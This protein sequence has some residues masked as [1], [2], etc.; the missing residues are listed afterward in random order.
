M[1]TPVNCTDSELSTFLRGLAEGYLP[2]YYSDTS[3]SAQSKS[4]PIASKSY[5]HG[6]KT[7]SFLGFPSLTMLKHSTESR[8]ED[9]LKSS[10]AAF[11]VRTFHAQEKGGGLKVKEA[12][13]GGKWQESLA[14]F[15][16]V[17]RSWK[18]RQLC[19]FAD[20]DESLETWPK[21]GIMQNGVASA[22]ETPLGPT[23]EIEFGFSLPTPTRCDCSKVSSNP[24]FWRRRLE[25]GRSGMDNLPEFATT[26]YPGGD[27]RIHP[28]L[29]EWLM[30]WPAGMTDLKPLETD[31]FQ[32]W[33]RSHGGYS[34]KE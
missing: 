11:P 29:H 33:L 1:S 27:G 19:L 3:P 12:E 15:D 30:G 10:R 8:G 25:S 26:I 32:L 14:R 21:W 4:N 20:L 28:L 23:C 7:V 16:P 6:K 13:C 34:V 2:T 17:S 24:D 9:L 22:H 5:T 18:I 31:K